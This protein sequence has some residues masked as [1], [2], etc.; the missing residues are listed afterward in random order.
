MN[1]YVA[2]AVGIPVGA[3]FIAPVALT[4]AS[5]AHADTGMSGYLGCVNSAGLLPKQQAEDWSPTIK[6]VEWNLNNAESPARSSSEIGS[7]AGY[8]GQAERCPCGSAVRHGQPL[9]TCALLCRAFD[10]IFIPLLIRGPTLAL[11]LSYGALLDNA[12]DNPIGKALVESHLRY[13]LRFNS[14]GNTRI[15][16]LL[17]NSNQLQVLGVVF[18]E[19]DF[20]NASHTVG[21]TAEVGASRRAHQH[22]RGD[23]RDGDGCDDRGSDVG[24]THGHTNTQL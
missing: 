18:P 2:A 5:P 24:E 9:V 1:K 6:I 14:R 3:M 17:D 10:E 8:G 7:H 19:R 20:G 21:V 22:G 15:Q 16:I 4:G 23:E 12:L 11:G 13:S